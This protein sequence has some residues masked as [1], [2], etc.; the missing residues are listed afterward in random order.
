VADAF[1]GRLAVIDPE[2]GAVESVRE[3]PAHNIR[4]LALSADGRHLLVSHQV[5]SGRATTSLADVH[6]GNLLTNNLRE[7]SLAGLS[8][9]DVIVDLSQVAY[10]RVESGE[11]RVG[12]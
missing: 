9:R 6:W 11:H 7:V 1:G 4:G 10:L 3:I 8:P 12:F 5:L 2:T